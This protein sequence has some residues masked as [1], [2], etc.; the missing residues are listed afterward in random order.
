MNAALC[1]GEKKL[2]T[3]R[4]TLRALSLQDESLYQEIYCDSDTMHYVGSPLSSEQATRSFRAALRQ[5]GRPQAKALLV[6]VIDNSTGASIGICGATLGVPRLGSAEV[7]IML[8]RAARGNGYSRYIL[9]GFID[10]IFK[11]LCLEQ[12]WVCYEARQEAVVRLNE[13]LGFVVCDESPSKFA[14]GQS[15]YIH[16][17]AWLGVC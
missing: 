3:S 7:G 15:A 10:S 2:A 8:K 11:S 5:T 12:V 14:G 4:F 16:R 9:G 6:A 1:P 17:N 13:G